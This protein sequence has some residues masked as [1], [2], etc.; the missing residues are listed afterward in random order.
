MTIA[1]V[2]VSCI[3]DRLVPLG[4]AC[5]QGYLKTN[6]IS[7][8]TFNFRATSYSLAKMAVNPLG[9]PIPPSFIMNHQDFPLLMHCINTI[10]Q[11]SDIE[12][13]TND[14]EVLQALVMDYALRVHEPFSDTKARLMGIKA[15]LDT[16]IS[17]LTSH[18]SSLAFSLD[19]MNIR[20]TVLLSALIKVYDPSIK[21]LW[22]G[23]TITQ[24][25]DA[26]QKLLQKGVCDGLVIGEGEA[27]LLAVALDTKLTKIPGI[28]T[29]NG[30]TFQYSKGI[31]LNLDEL[32]T[33]DY[34]NIPL[35]TYFNLLS[36]YRSRGC[37]HR[38][39]FCAEWF[40]CGARFRVRSV[41]KVTEDMEAV[42]DKFKPGYIIFGE[43]LI[44][45]DLHYFTQLCD[46]LIKSNFDLTYG[47][48]FRANITPSLAQ[49][50]VHAGFDD[51]WVG[52]ETFSDEE[53]KNISKGINV[54]ENLLN[55]KY[56]TEA[57]MNMIAMLVVGTGNLRQEEENCR[58][59]VKV[60][61]EF[62]KKKITGE[63]GKSRPLSIQWRTSPM[64]VVPGSFDYKN[65]NFPM[66]PWT[67]RSELDSLE[68]KTKIKVI[69]QELSDLPYNFRRMIPPKKV[70]EFTKRIQ[71][72][73]RT[74][75]FAI[76]GIT[77]YYITS[78]VKL[79]K[80][81]KLQKKVERMGS[82]VENL[83]TVAQRK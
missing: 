82:I 36:L 34:S 53:L 46:E 11:T 4:L 20:E 69:E 5:L 67:C 1:L 61:K 44:N 12:C 14:D 18:Y 45:D 22:G 6:D 24:S 25:P 66:Y 50:A 26:F 2:K 30:H 55:L 80:R 42:I 73:D 63:D 57:G 28:M 64:C 51:A 35:D 17:K 13:D 56:F 7:V 49:K 10:Q 38:C 3:D 39:S 52:V 75:G 60:I 77:K 71:E 29:W 68:S 23:A 43:S 74:S 83:T 78:L 65:R 54:N 31:Q 48:H 37:T 21:I 9:S 79:R 8:D 27:P 58:N 40:L 70:M 81:E 19:Y 62:A 59:T 16:I 33:P 15:Y 41:Q 72:A 76:G 32:P 47:T